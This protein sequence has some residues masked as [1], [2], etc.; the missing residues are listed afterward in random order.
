MLHKLSLLSIQCLLLVGS[1]CPGYAQKN[2]IQSFTLA[3]ESFNPSAT[4][5]IKYDWR[6]DLGT[7]II[8]YNSTYGINLISGFLQPNHYRFKELQ[9]WKA[10]N[11]AI[12]LRYVPNQQAVILYSTAPDLTI[13]GFHLFNSKGQLLQKN[14]VKTASSFL[15]KLIDLSSYTNGVYYLLVFY[16][17]DN[18]TAA[19]LPSYWTTTLKL[20]KQ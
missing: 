13:H 7:Y 9:Q 10:Y 5:A 18:R 20:L 14:Q 16:L 17:P 15:S 3:S 2:N 12:E 1:T 11:P 8:G 4:N 6:L 19:P